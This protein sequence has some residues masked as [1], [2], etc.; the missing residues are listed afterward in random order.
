M[1]EPPHERDD[2]PRLSPV[3]PPRP[4]RDR[5]DALC[6]AF[7]VELL[8]PRAELIGVQDAG[9]IAERCD[10]SLAAARRRVR[11]LHPPHL[12]SARPAP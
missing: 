12:A 10:V 9:W 2:T 6:D 4:I 3:R 8:M 7:A 11:E 1:N 5:A